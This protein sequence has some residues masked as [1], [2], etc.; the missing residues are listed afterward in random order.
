MLEIIH[1]RK[2]EAESADG[3]AIEM[4]SKEKPDLPP[5]GRLVSSCFILTSI[6]AVKIL[7]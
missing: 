7:K 5:E 3:P 2:S 1:K 4:L 6:S